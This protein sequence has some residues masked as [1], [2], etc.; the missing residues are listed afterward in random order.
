MAGGGGGVEAVAVA[1]AVEAV[2]VEAVAFVALLAGTHVAP[3][4]ELSQT[5]SI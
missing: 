1:V 5:W 3:Y 4:C 2:A